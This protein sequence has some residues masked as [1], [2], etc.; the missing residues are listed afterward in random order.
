MRGLQPTVGDPVLHTL[1]V[2]TRL[3]TFAG[4]SVRWLL[5]GRRL[6]KQA[7]R[8]GW[9]DSVHH[10]TPKD[11]DAQIPQFRLDNPNLAPEESRGFGYWLWRPY[12]LGMELAS[13]S[14]GECLLFL[15]A[16]C[17]LNQNQQSEVRFRT[18][19]D[20]ANEYGSLIMEINEPIDKWC[21]R[22]LLQEFALGDCSSQ[23]LLV[24]PGV[25]FL[26][27]TETN[28]ALVADWIKWGRTQNHHYL[29]D[30]PSRVPELSTFQ[31]HR[32]D[33]AILTCLSTQYP[34]HKIPQ[35]TYFPQKWSELGSPY[36][37]WALRNST[38]FD[39]ESGGIVS[40]VISKWRRRSNK[41]PRR[42][43]QHR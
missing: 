19:V 15:D 6:A 36:P 10:W 5:A 28:Q 29:D 25:F 1:V 32:H 3:V 26:T 41:F 2:V 14:K 35:E 9:F 42:T 43:H 7:S 13:M 34:I 31:E 12:I 30:S 27:K 8:S 39:L 17:Q 20:T 11:L 40:E 24:E 4:G 21:K 37:I 16:G 22:D 38:P 18:Y 23:L 33:Q